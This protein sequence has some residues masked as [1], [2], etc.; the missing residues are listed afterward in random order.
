MTEPDIQTVLAKAINDEKTSDFVFIVEQKKIYVHRMILAQRS[1]VFKVLVLGNMKEA[2]QRQAEIT[3][4]TIKHDHFLSFLNHVYTGKTEI[5]ARNVMFLLNLAKMY[6]FPLLQKS[7]VSFVEECLV[8]QN[9]LELLFSATN[10]NEVGISKKCLQLIRCNLATVL[11]DDAMKNLSATL[12][13]EI[14]ADDLLDTKEEDLFA[15]AQRWITQNPELSTTITQ[16]VLSQIRF[17]L[18]PVQFLTTVVK[19]SQLLPIEQYLE[20]LEFQSAPNVFQ[21]DILKQK[22]FQ[23]R[24]TPCTPLK[25]SSTLKGTNLIL[26]DDDKTVTGTKYHES[27]VSTNI[28]QDMVYKISLEV[29]I[30]PTNSGSYLAIGVIGPEDVG[31]RESFAY[32]DSSAYIFCS[33]QGHM[34]SYGPGVMNHIVYNSPIWKSEDVITLEI[35]VPQSTM[36]LLVN[37]NGIPEA[38][39]SGFGSKVRLLASLYNTHVVTIL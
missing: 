34:C 2:Q 4:P 18:I 36:D 12:L 35:N 7:C 29:V 20:A 24:K 22:R 5:S 31:C 9:A 27:V 19:S 26:S 14:L 25:W 28:L 33:Y 16:Q 3:D 37:G 11:T 38:R 17:P 39:L 23:K 13:T 6:S 10:L 1:P 30:D 8:P 32:N 15:I 21:G